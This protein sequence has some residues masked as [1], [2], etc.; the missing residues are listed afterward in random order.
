MPG[1]SGRCRGSKAN[2]GQGR[3]PCA[4]EARVQVGVSGCRAGEAAEAGLPAMPTSMVSER[5]LLASF[6]R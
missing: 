1:G 3:E 2:T 6:C 5:G 4:K